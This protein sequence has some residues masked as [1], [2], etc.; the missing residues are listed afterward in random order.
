MNR[1]SFKFFGLNLRSVH[2][3]TL[4]TCCLVSGQREKT[5]DSRTQL[6]CL[7]AATATRQSKLVNKQQFSPNA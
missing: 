7:Q 4:Q 6:I 3:L 1:H 2:E 5:T